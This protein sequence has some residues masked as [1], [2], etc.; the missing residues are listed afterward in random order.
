M[1]QGQYELGDVELCSFLG[2]TSFS[3]QMPKKLPSALEIRYEVQIRICLEAELEPDEERGI[4]RALE[5][6][7]FTNGVGNFLFCYDFLFGEN[8]HGIDAF[9]VLLA[10]LENLSKGA[11]SDKLK[12]FKVTGS[13]GS[14]RLMEIKVGYYNGGSGGYGPCNAHR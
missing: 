10:D 4:Q 1:L 8:L 14:L 5:D 7:A 9:C 11:S 6:L 3:L 12:E 13:Q 2:K